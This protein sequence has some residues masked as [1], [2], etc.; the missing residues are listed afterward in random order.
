M[1]KPACLEV[2]DP[3]A[4]PPAGQRTW[5]RRAGF[6]ALVGGVTLALVGL[7]ASSLAP[8]SPSSPS[9]PPLPTSP[10]ALPHTPA[11]AHVDPNADILASIVARR[12]RVSEVATREFVRAA[13]LEAERLKLDPLLVVAVMAV[14][15]RFN[16][17]AQSDSGAM[18]LMQVIPRFHA[19]KFDGVAHVAVLDPRANIRAGARILKEYIARGG[20]EP[21]GL[22]LYNGAAGDPES[23]YA[24][25]VLSERQWLKGALR[26]ALRRAL[27]RG[28]A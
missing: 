27:D 12:Y 5:Q 8:S 1:S 15:S 18:G 26:D 14:E 7:P 3:P 22:Q 6:A 19:E 10:L 28:R 25:R 21:A 4:R 17:V 9:S 13:Y 24:T 23:A 11:K 20:T 16:P 2:R